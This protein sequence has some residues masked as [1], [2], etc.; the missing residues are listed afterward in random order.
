MTF[1][2]PFLLSGRLALSFWQAYA[3]GCGALPVGFLVHR[4]VVRAWFR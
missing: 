3:L 4:V 1:F 2:L